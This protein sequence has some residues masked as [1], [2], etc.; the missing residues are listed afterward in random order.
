MSA[1]QTQ[2]AYT[3]TS[4]PRFDRNTPWKRRDRPCATHPSGSKRRC[5]NPSQTTSST[6]FCLLS[7]ASWR[8][9]F[10]TSSTSLFAGYCD[11]KTRFLFFGWSKNV[12]C[13]LKMRPRPRDFEARAGLWDQHRRCSP[14]SRIHAITAQRSC[15]CCA[16]AGSR[17]TASRRQLSSVFVSSR[18]SPFDTVRA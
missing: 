6:S 3:R 11:F 16:N 14:S 5:G 12:P 13:L 2:E 8:S 1:R 17:R 18:L 15:L 9:S 4:N 7:P 10:S